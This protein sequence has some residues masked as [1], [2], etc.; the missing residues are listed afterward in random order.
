MYY[1]HMHGLVGTKRFLGRA[2]RTLL[3]H[4]I[5]NTIDDATQRDRVRLTWCLDIVLIYRQGRS[6]ALR[7]RMLE[8]VVL[9]KRPR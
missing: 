1:I 8:H 4:S 6:I 3:C 5:P 7:L 9:E 2:E